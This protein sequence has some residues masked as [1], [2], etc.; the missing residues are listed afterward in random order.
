MQ[1]VRLDDKALLDKLS[2]SAITLLTKCF[3]QSLGCSARSQRNIISVP[4]WSRRENC[5]RPAQRSEQEQAFFAG[6]KHRYQR[7][8]WCIQAGA[9]CV[10][11]NGG[12]ITV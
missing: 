10:V 2:S 6:G 7:Q 8:I 5:L 1:I 3:A 11:R 4:H 12:A 9:L